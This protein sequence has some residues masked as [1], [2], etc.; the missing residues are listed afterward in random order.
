VLS[1]GKMTDSSGFGVG[2][3][4][5]VVQ[6]GGWVGKMMGMDGVGTG[7]AGVEQE[8]VIKIKERSRLV[9]NRVEGRK[10]GF[11]LIMVIV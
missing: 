11:R 8:V 6:G 4:V 5:R 10:D 3:V 9:L 2:E 7:V 1:G